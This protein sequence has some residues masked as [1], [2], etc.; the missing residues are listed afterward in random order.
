MRKISIV[1][2][3]LVT[4]FVMALAGLVASPIASASENKTVRVY[5]KFSSGS[6]VLTKSQK[7]EIK[8]AVASSGSDATFIATGTAGK[9]PGLSNKKAKALAK[10]RAKAIKAY[11]VSLGVSET[12]VTTEAKVTN[13]GVDPSSVRYPTPAPTPTPTVTA[14]NSAGTGSGSGGGGVLPAL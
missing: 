4:S 14:T 12:S 6:S 13:I 9:L 11:L 8:K 7:A 3:V 10:A 1:L 2:T 5:A